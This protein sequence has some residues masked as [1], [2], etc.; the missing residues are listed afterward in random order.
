MF[1]TAL[2]WAW[3]VGHMNWVTKPAQIPKKFALA[4]YQFECDIL[5]YWAIFSTLYCMWKSDRGMVRGFS[6]T[7][8]RARVILELHRPL[9]AVITASEL[10]PTSVFTST[11]L[12]WFRTPCKKN[13]NNFMHKSMSVQEYFR[14]FKGQDIWS[15]RNKFPRKNFWN[16]I[17]AWNSQKLPL[18]RGW[19]E[20]ASALVLKSKCPLLTSPFDPR[21]AYLFSRIALLFSL[22]GLFFPGIT[23][24]F[25]RSALLFLKNA[26]SFSRTV[27]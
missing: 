10:E 1:I 12:F 2:L 14:E 13:E 21:I 23:L 15:V 6:R 4:T 16:F 26:L 24:L 9:N 20:V 25:S 11:F 17:L 7:C 5:V 8:N 22:S 18:Q 27:F 19:D 3:A